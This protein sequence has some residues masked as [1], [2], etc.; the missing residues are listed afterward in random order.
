MQRTVLLARQMPWL[1]SSRMVPFAIPSPP[2]TVPGRENTSRAKQE[3]ERT[4]NKKRKLSA[5][6]R[7]QLLGIWPFR[8]NRTPASSSPKPAVVARC[9]VAT[10]SCLVRQ[11][12]STPLIPAGTANPSFGLLDFPVNADCLFFAFEATPQRIDGFGLFSQATGGPPARIID[13]IQ[14]GRKAA[15]IP[16]HWLRHR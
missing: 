7:E 12:C 3:Y 13:F 5:E 10:R 16:N 15:R 8:P 6:Q 9:P 11:A 2:P 4:Q 1:A 14:S